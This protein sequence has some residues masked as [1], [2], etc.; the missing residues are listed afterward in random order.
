MSSLPKLEKQWNS[1]KLIQSGRE[2]KFRPFTIGEQKEIMLIKST[3]E[4]DNDNIKLYKAIIDM[5]ENCVEDLKVI[6]M[7]PVELEKLFYDIRSVADGNI[8]KFKMPCKNDE[9]KE[10]DNFYQAELEVNTRD[11]FKLS[12]SVFTKKITIPYQS[13]PTVA[14]FRQPNLKDVFKINEK[15]YSSDNERGFDIPNF[16][17]EKVLVGEESF[18][19]F[20]YDDAKQ[21]I[22]SINDANVLKEII[23]FY[24]NQPK[25]VCAKDLYCDK[26]EKVINFD[27]ENVTS[28]F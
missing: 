9:C 24:K 14:V 3:I 5:V 4:E 27:K 17:L 7:Y 25:L 19:D 21:F 1:T 23:D 13:K 8:L 10:K 18:T 20:T 26:C 15:E 2:V 22:D 28:F 12:D 16:C 6:E 11:D